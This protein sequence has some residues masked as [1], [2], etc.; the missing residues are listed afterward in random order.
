M[1][2]IDKLVGQDVTIWTQYIDVE[3]HLRKD[4]IGYYAHLNGGM[5]R[6]KDHEVKQISPDNII[7][8]ER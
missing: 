1:K 2:N 6:F 8:L 4:N 3:T 5:I 7:V